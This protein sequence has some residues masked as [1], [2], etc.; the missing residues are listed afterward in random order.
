MP[1]A[2]ALTLVADVR[3][4]RAVCVRGEDGTGGAGT[5]PAAVPTAVLLLHAAQ[6]VLIQLALPPLAETPGQ[7]KQVHRWRE[8]G[9]GGGG[10]DKS[11][12]IHEKEV[13]LIPL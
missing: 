11:L 1:G 10:R 4:F 5:V 2:H 8:E 12:F 13:W 3:V 7:T 6:A 9:G